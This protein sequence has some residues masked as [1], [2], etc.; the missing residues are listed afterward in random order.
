MLPLRALILAAPLGD[1]EKACKN[2]QNLQ[3]RVAPRGPQW[4]KCCLNL[5]KTS[6]FEAT[7]SDAIPAGPNFGHASR[8]HWKSLQKPAKIY[9]K[10]WLP[11]ARV[12]CGCDDGVRVHCGWF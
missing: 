7:T 6:I 12:D 5:G 11:E 8:G 1:I 10:G 4:P 9:R 3:E 2:L